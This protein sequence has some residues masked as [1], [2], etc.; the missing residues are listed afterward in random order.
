VHSPGQNGRDANID[1]NHRTHGMLLM[2]P[3][4]FPRYCG[5][6]FAAA[7]ISSARSARL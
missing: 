7:A 4:S 1:P 3:A 5:T 2:G 6:F